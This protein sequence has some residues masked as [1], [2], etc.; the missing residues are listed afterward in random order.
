M[1][2]NSGPGNCPRTEFLFSD[3]KLSRG[4]FFNFPGVPP[5][6]E[7]RLE[8]VQ[9]ILINGLWTGLDPGFADSPVLN[10]SHLP[11][12]RNRFSLQ[13]DSLPT[14]KTDP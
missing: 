12:S 1:P 14:M 3:R 8:A 9:S 2:S 6:P 7:P 4:F 5:W 10:T 11:S 13:P